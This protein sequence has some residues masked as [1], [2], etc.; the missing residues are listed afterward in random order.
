MR[1]NYFLC[2]ILFASTSPSWAQE[3]NI[4]AIK[5][6]GNSVIDQ[7][8][9]LFHIDAKVGDP[10]DSDN[11]LS[12]FQKLWDTGF[13]DNLQLDVTDGEQG[14]IVTFIVEERPRVRLVE[15]IGSKE[16]SSD[17]S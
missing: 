7:D 6:E 11:L 4:E 8:T 5:I 3:N 10:Y 2:V 9:Y 16:L 17:A 13:L 12:D 14:K 1:W 15:F